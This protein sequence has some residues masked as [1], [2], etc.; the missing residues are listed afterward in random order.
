MGQEYLSN[1]VT[2]SQTFN[3]DK[4]N[5]LTINTNAEYNQN[6]NFI[7]M[8]TISIIINER[9]AGVFFGKTTCDISENTFKQNIYISQEQNKFEQI[10]TLGH[11]IYLHAFKEL[12]IVKKDFKMVSTKNV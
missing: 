2:G 6:S 1:F 8:P 10:V 9:T 12:E 11:E 4:T 3:L 7:L 5:S